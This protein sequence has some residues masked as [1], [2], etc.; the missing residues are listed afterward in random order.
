MRQQR[1]N[2]IEYRFYEHL[3]YDGFFNCSNNDCFVSNDPDYAYGLLAVINNRRSED[4]KIIFVVGLDA[5]TTLETSRILRNN[6]K[7]LYR[8]VAMKQ[9]LGKEFYCICR[10]R[11]TGDHLVPLELHELIVNR[12]VSHQ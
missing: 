12:I 8:K 11:K 6:L 4:K 1:I 5:D 2:P 10:F 9:L 3:K 7:R